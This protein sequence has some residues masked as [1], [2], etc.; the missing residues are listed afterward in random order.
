MPASVRLDFHDE[1]RGVKTHHTSKHWDAQHTPE[2]RAEHAETARVWYA[3]RMAWMQSKEAEAL[4]AWTREVR[5][6]D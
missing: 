6:D 3:R 4:S 1:Q 5:G 2:E